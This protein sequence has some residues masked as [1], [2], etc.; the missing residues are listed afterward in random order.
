MENYNL[1]D[2]GHPQVHFQCT[3]EGL[4]AL[5]HVYARVRK[6]TYTVADIF[7][8]CA[9]AAD[10]LRAL[11]AALDLCERYSNELMPRENLPKRYAPDGKA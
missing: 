3:E 5:R 11:D 6:G 1:V 10:T 7:R 4:R 2:S 9:A 8:W